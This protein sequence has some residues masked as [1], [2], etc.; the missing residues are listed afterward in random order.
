MRFTELQIWW[1]AN[2]SKNYIGRLNELVKAYNEKFGENRTKR[3]IEDVMYRHSIRNR[4]FGEEQ[5][6][7]LRDNAELCSWTELTVRYNKIF[8]ENR[9]RKAIICMCHRL[10][11]QKWHMNKDDK[12]ESV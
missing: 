6:Q 1:I 7:W 10:G 2:N 12:K 5:K 4:F 9:T 11:L 8:E 3:S